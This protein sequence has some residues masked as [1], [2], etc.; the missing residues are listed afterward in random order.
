M[1][2]QQHATAFQHR[3]ALFSDCMEYRFELLIRWNFSLP[4]FALI[5]LNPSKASAFIDDPTVFRQIK[6]M[7]ALGAGALL[8]LNAF[9][10]RSTDP[11]GMLTA[12]DPYGEWDTPGHILHAAGRHKATRVFAAW[13]N[14]AVHRNRARDVR[15][16]ARL[17][18]IP[19]ECF[20]IT[21]TG[22]PEHP[23]Y[24]PYSLQPVLLDEAVYVKR[25]KAPNPTKELFA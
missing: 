22:Q 6:R 17:H 10:I 15:N 20:A 3:T 16:A 5:G 25:V 9:A 21:K 7:T 4:V 2:T 18:G 12:A 8:M 14:H 13:G 24:L 11:K 1:I 19:L 23:L